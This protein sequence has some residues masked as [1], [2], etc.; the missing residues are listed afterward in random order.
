[1]NPCNVPR[2]APGTEKAPCMSAIIII[3]ITTTTSICDDLYGS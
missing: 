1:M 2:T 3:I